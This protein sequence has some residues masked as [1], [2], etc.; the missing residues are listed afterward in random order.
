MLQQYLERKDD[1]EWAIG[2]QGGSKEGE[3]R[4]ER[5]KRIL[6]ETEDILCVKDRAH[7]VER[8]GRST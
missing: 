6:K 5:I 7:M 3:N 8:T 1:N 2:F 4:E